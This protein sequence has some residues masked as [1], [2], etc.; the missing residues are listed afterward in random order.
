MAAFV[1]SCFGVLLYLWL[2]FGGTLA[3]GGEGLP[4]PRP[5]PRGDPARPAGRRAHL[6]RAGRQGRQDRTRDRATRTDATIEMQTRATR[7]CRATPGRCCARSRLLGETYV[8]LLAGNRSKG[9]APRGRRCRARRS[10]TTV[11]LDE[12]F[13][14]FD[15]PTRQ[16]VPD[17]DAVVRSAAVAGRGADI[18]AA[19]RQPARVRRPA[20]RS[21]CA[22]STP[23]RGRSPRRS[24][25]PARSSTRSASARASCARW[26][27]TRTGSSRSP[28]RAT[29]ELAQIFRELPR[30]ERESRITLPR[31]TE[32]G[33]AA[34][35]TVKQLQ[36]AATAS[37]ADVRGAQRGQRRSSGPSSR[38]SVPSSTRRRRGVPAFEQT[39]RAAAAAVRRLPALPAQPQPDRP[40]PRPQQARDHRAARELRRRHGGPGH[41][42]EPDALRPRHRAAGSAV[43]VVPPAPARLEP[44]QRLWRARGGGPARHRPARLRQPPVRQ[45]RSDLAADRPRGRRTAAGARGDGEDRFV[46]GAGQ[47][48]RGSCG[49][50]ATRSRRSCWTRRS[51]RIRGRRP[52][53]VDARNVVDPQDRNVARTGCTQQELYPGFGTSYPQL[54]VEP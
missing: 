31:L 45:G 9:D 54:R 29:S 28:P 24:P 16:G 3:A 14:S 8:D 48:P 36:P 13:R 19:L 51:A 40:L 21:S 23:S 26:S 7:P 25:R 35:P 37:S 53:T 34:L 42:R 38:R 50:T 15:A 47:M 17:L 12:I 52:G 5:L 18:N 49:S 20:P 11:E 22:S 39:L 44:Q 27:R 2:S 32:F 43:A 4:L 33:D 6:R 10:R 41:E 30:F 46:R 1:L